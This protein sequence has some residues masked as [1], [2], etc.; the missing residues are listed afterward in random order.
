MLRNIR[1]FAILVAFCAVPAHA[2]LVIDVQGVAHPEF[3]NW[4]WAPVDDLPA[5]IVPFKRALYEAVVSEF[6]HLARPAPG[7]V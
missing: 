3:T 2:E 6:R 5:L 7:S 1:L 4:R